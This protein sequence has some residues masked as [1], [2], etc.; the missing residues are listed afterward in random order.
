MSVNLELSS[1][2]RAGKSQ[3]SFKLQRK[4]MPKIVQ[5][6]V[7]L[8]SLKTKQNKNKNKNQTGKFLKRW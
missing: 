1:D 8:H 6:T 2:R 3:F 4:A 5:T 7:Q